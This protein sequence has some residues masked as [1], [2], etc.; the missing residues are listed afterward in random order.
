MRRIVILLISVV[1]VATMDAKKKKDPVVMTVAGRDVPL[2]EFVYMAKK[3]NSVDLKDMKSVENFAE[4]FKN[5]KLKVIDAENLEI[6]KSDRFK[7]E[8][9]DYCKQL[10]QSFLSDKPSEDSAMREVYERTKVIPAFRHL[11][12]RFPEGE[13]LA[14]DTVDAYNRAM[15]AY[16]RIKQGETLEEIGKSFET[17]NSNGLD[18]YVD[19]EYVFPLQ[20][21]KVLEDKVFD[22][23]VGEISEPFRSPGGY[24]IVELYRKTPNPGRV[25]IAHI[26]TR[27]PSFENI[28]PE[29]EEATRKKSDSI[30][31]LA[32]S[33]QDFAQL[34]QTF[35]DDTLNGKDGGLLPYFGMGE[36]VAPFEK[37]AFAFTE[38]GEISKP[39]RTRFGYHVLKFI[40]KKDTTP[41]VELENA[42]YENMRRSDR[43]F[44]LYKGFD[45]K[46]KKQ[47]GYVF[48]PEA[49]EEIKAVAADYFPA[50]TPFVNRTKEMS[51][52]L[53]RFDTIEFPQWDFIEYIY[54]MPQSNKQFTFDF[55]DE[56]FNYYIHEIVTELERNHLEQNYPEY[57]MLMKEYND[58]ILLFEISNKR[59]W[60]QPAEEQA[61]LEAEWQKELNEKYPVKINRSVLKQIKKYVD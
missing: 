50:D 11:L 61:K 45:N 17:N 34:A 21:V 24:H 41:F 54:R 37:T 22:M 47:Y 30:Y 10:Q 26:L 14:K 16:H 23:N 7:R 57:N 35:S 25:R 15:A 2:S 8:L 29:D 9:Q 44:D 60:S 55:L 49:Y 1:V 33:G 18:V 42:I 20:M 28:T 51:K 38:I 5:Y 32:I 19:V 3:D 39:V 58:G 6:N 48:Y 52:L 56:Q 46:V 40:D 4:L 36:M 13:L 27:F 43:K 59:I 12:F 53:I 31:Q